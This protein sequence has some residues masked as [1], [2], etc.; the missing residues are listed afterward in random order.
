MTK[1]RTHSRNKGR[2]NTRKK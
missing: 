2:T 1:E